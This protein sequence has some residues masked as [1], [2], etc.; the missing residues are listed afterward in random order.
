MARVRYMEREDL[1]AKHQH[2]W[3]EIAGSRGGV[4]LNFRALLNGPE[5]TSRMAALGA[6]V[7]FETPLPA[8]VKALAVLTTAR[9]SE[10]DYVWTVNEPQARSAGLEQ[11]VINAI[12]ERRAPQALKAE[13]AT[14][15]RFTLELLKQHRVSDATFRAVQGR[16]GD[17]GVVD[18]LVLIGYYF[19]LSHAL[20]ALEVELQPGVTSTLSR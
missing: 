16:L 3:D 15:V 14:I 10:G 1:A 12:R 8:R 5:V 17:A 11:E 20:S 2:V 7:R 4:N 19:T 13:D 18:L 9:E 6:Y